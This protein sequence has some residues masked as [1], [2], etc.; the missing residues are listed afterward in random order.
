M[1]TMMMMMIAEM[2]KPQLIKSQ[3]KALEDLFRR[4][5]EVTGEEDLE[6]L[7]TKCLQRE[8]ALSNLHLISDD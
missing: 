3:E 4:L 1:M 7:V 6:M 8:S 2:K 5:Q